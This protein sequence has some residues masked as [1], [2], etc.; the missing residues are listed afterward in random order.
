MTT[1]ACVVVVILIIYSIVDRQ[2]T[3]KKIDKDI[4]KLEN[5]NEIAMKETKQ[6]AEMYALENLEKENE[7]EFIK[8]QMTEQ[9]II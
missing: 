2:K 8:L 4:A 3:N 7:V 6:I 9:G 5:M 1:I